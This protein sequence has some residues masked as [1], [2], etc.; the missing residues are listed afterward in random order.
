MA[1]RP[2]TKAS[3]STTDSTAFPPPKPKRTSLATEFSAAFGSLCDAKGTMMENGDPDSDL[4]K[5][6]LLDFVSHM[7]CFFSLPLL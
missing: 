6:A 1:P 4:Y 2:S 5:L 3:S 7:V